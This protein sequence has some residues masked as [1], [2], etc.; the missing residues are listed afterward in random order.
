MT[1]QVVNGVSNFFGPRDRFEGENGKYK[2]EGTGEELVIYFS[3]DSYSTVSFVL[4][5]GTVI[6][7]NAMVEVTQVAALTG[8]SPVIN[9]GKATAEGTDR[10]AQISE[11]QAEAL[12]T[13]SIASAGALAV[14]TPLTADTTIKIALGGTGGPTWAGGRFKVV[15]P[16][17]T[18]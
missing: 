13:Y 18:I 6:T 17:R 14:N 3:G 16:Y 4:P 1:K 9:I 5:A 11:A 10:L 8:T 7:G 2:T 12:G 15:V